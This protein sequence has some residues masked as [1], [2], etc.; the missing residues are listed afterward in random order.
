MWEIIIGRK[1]LDSNNY[2]PWEILVPIGS[3]SS[4]G[5]KCHPKKLQLTPEIHLN[6]FFIEFN[7]YTIAVSKFIKYLSIFKSVCYSAM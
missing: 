1:E 4:G 7:G 5:G 2:S 3:L 6:F